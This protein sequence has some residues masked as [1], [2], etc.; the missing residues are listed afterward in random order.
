MKKQILTFLNKLENENVDKKE[1]LDKISFYQ[2]ERLIHLIVT[3]LVAISAILFT[4]M[5]LL[6]NNYLLLII[7]IILFILFTF[8]IIHYYFLENSIQKM[9]LY[10]DKKKDD[11]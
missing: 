10:Y 7:S 3:C 4:L 1:L 8:Y 6:L 2:H 5:G 11:K 9:Y